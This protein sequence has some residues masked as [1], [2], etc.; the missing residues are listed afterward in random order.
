MRQERDGSVA[1]RSHSPG[2][3]GFA[4]QAGETHRHGREALG[5]DG[6]VPAVTVAPAGISLF[7]DVRD[8]AAG[9]HFAIPA[10]DASAT[11]SGEAEKP[12]ETHHILRSRPEQF[13][14]RWRSRHARDWRSLSTTHIGTCRCAN[15][16]ATA[17]S[18]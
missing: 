8:L 1:V 10:D 4:N 12:N 18:F 11:K 5:G 2:S 3:G 6:V 13:A 9:R 15:R 14:C 17:L 16:S 7:F